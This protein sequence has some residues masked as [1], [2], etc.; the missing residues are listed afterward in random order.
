MISLPIGLTTVC[1]FLFQPYG[2]AAQGNQTK[3]DTL[4][5]TSPLEWIGTGLAGSGMG[6]SVSCSQDGRRI[7]SSEVGYDHHRGKVALKIKTSENSTSKKLSQSSSPS[8]TWSE[9]TWIYGMEQGDYFGLSTSLAGNG[10]YLVIGAPGDD[11]AKPDA[12]AV[13]IYQVPLNEGNKRPVQKLVGSQMGENFGFSVALNNDGSIL[14]ITAPFSSVEINKKSAPECGS[15]KIYHS[16][17]EITS[18]E[19]YALLG[20]V[21]GGKAGD[22]MGEGGLVLSSDGFTVAVHSPNAEK[23]NGKGKVSVYGIN[24]DMTRLGGDDSTSAITLIQNFW[25]QISNPS[26]LYRGIA[27]SKTGTHFAIQTNEKGTGGQ[28][29][30]YEKTPPTD[31]NSQAFFAQVAD[32]INGLNKEDGFGRTI[33]FANGHTTLVIGQ[34]STYGRIS[35]FKY[36]QTLNNFT[37]QATEKV[38]GESEGDS[39]GASVAISDDGTVIIVGAFT[40]RINANPSGTTFIYEQKCSDSSFNSL[41]GASSAFSTKI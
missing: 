24:T 29:V 23:E 7:V 25:D 20:E 33:H 9:S 18:V 17:Q 1:V 41:R 16:R 8:W 2:I 27:L 31:S 10:Q 34:E 21:Y 15:L 22:K 14:A 40:Y 3:C 28:V 38:L 11:E 35:I 37:R 26:I 5:S 6:F 13:S 36:S 30:I 19:M 39:F 12:G 4:S 32:P